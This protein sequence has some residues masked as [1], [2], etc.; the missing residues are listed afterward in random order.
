MFYTNEVPLD[1]NG[2]YVL[3]NNRKTVQHTPFSCFVLYGLLE[4]V[5]GTVYLQLFTSIKVTCILF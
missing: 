1:T 4:L 2:D 3:K 5:S